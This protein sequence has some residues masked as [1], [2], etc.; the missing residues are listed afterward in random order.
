MIVKHWL[1]LIGICETLYAELSVVTI[2]LSKTMTSKMLSVNLTKMSYASWQDFFPGCIQ[3]AHHSVYNTRANQIGQI[4]PQ[5][6]Y[7]LHL[8]CTII[9]CH[10]IFI[11]ATHKLIKVDDVVLAECSSTP[12]LVMN[13]LTQ[14][15]KSLFVCNSLMQKHKIGKAWYY[16]LC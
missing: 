8:F 4:S 13:F 5:G 2:L 15:N 11:Y 7:A 1:L 9:V 10:M 16:V 6:I 12:N 3:R 14:C